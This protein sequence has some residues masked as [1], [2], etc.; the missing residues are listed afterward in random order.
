[1]SARVS[2]P[3]ANRTLARES[4]KTRSRNRNLEN[5]RGKILNGE[6]VVVLRRHESSC[7]RSLYLLM[8]R[9]AFVMRTPVVLVI[10]PD[11]VPGANLG[12][13]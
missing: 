8:V 1:M 5:P 10:L 9:R 6:R 11:S 2:I 3:A 13:Q 12:I 7:R 4:G